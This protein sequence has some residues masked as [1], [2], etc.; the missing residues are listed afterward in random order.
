MIIESHTE[1]KKQI[2]S[3]FLENE[4]LVNIN[5]LTYQFNTI[6]S[7]V[8]N[9][10]NIINKYPYFLLPLRGVVKFINER[11]SIPN[12]DKFVLNE[13]GIIF[14]INEDFSINEKS[15]EETI[16]S[17]FGFM[18]GKNERKETILNEDDF[19]LLIKCTF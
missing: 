14:N 4:P 18:K 5:Y 3:T 9:Q 1:A 2:Y 8:T 15:N 10:Q 6:Q 17:I 12:M 7:L 19:N 11:L 16:Y 13:D